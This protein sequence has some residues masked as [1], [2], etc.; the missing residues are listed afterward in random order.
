[1]KRVIIF[2]TF[3]LIVGLVISGCN[4]DNGG[5]AET[6]TP[7]ITLAG[8]NGTT[9]SLQE[10][11]ITTLEA[12]VQTCD[13]TD[14]NFTYSWYLD[15][16][17]VP[18]S[19]T[20]KYD[21]ISC[22]SDVGTHKLR[23][24]AASI[25]SDLVIETDFTINVVKVA[26]PERPQCYLSSME[27]IR[28]GYVT[29]F[30]D[31]TTCLESY[32]QEYVCD[33]DANFAVG[34]AKN[35]LF[36]MSIEDLYRNHTSLTSEDIKDLGENVIIPI[37]NH[38]KVVLEKAPRDWSFYEEGLYDIVISDGKVP[39]FDPVEISLHG[40]FDLGDVYFLV[41]SAKALEGW[42]YVST[43]FNGLLDH[44]LKVPFDFSIKSE[45]KRFVEKM[46]SDP[47]F[48]TFVG[49]NGEEGK[50]NLLLARGAFIDSVHLSQQMFSEIMSE[51]D[52][53][54][55]DLFRYW[56]CGKDAVCPP[57][58]ECPGGASW[59]D[60]A[61]GDPPEYD[62]MVYG[63][64][65][66]AGNDY[67]DRNLNGK[68]DEGWQT[69]GPDSDGSECNNRYDDGEPI[70]TAIFGFPDFRVINIASDL[71]QML[72]A[73]NEIELS[74]IG[75]D[76]PLDYDRMIGQSEGTVKS[77]MDSLGI[78][79]PEIRLSEAFLTPT[80]ARM[81]VPLYSISNRFFIIDNEYEPF[82]DTG[83]DG[84]E[85]EYEDG[86][87][88]CL[89]DPSPYYDPVTNP[90][91]NH[92]NIDLSCAPT[93]NMNDGYDNDGDGKVDEY[94]RTNFGN[95][96]GDIGAEGNLVF[97]FIDD[98]DNGL[99][100]PGEKHE[101][102]E[103][104]GIP[105]VAGTADNGKWDT[106]DLPHEWPNGP[107]VGPV[108]DIQMTDPRDGTTHEVS[109]NNPDGEL[110]DFYYL[111]FPDPTFSRFLIFPDEIKNIENQPL[112]DHAKLHRFISK[113]FDLAQKFGIY[114]NGVHKP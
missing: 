14:R 22:G 1:M 96:P 32:L 37:V 81:I 75:P 98:N 64:C 93:C 89:T 94:N 83:Y 54:S 23:I 91:P 41:A 63:S 104:I 12:Q 72:I 27:A 36:F 85:D 33:I 112:N 56:D 66:E 62:P 44:F 26:N 97:D 4:G 100:D 82:E 80:E 34:L 68:C 74:L 113:I 10:G 58:S 77:V 60:P 57:A 21:F 2:I 110:I 49:E 109:Q 5:T 88:G 107:D 86:N 101:P 31:A 73:L 69:L 35:V 43:A 7:R 106:K 13:E 95:F 3:V 28:K 16:G 48:L 99:H 103:D 46:V 39:Y 71:S 65:E 51:T 9:I 105:G 38:F 47:T 18:V 84:C 70:G 78:P 90:D 55:D 17:D 42:Y 79:Y 40:E 67:E 114:D 24:V 61:N 20:N 102:F 50:E 59:I 87:G 19:S 25:D 108:N 76:H 29:E 6:C 111:F 8:F 30:T 15:G 45:I 11:K 52:D 92:D 53:Q